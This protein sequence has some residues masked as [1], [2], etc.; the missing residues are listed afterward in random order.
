MA[1]ILTVIRVATVVAVVAIIVGAEVVVEVIAVMIISVIFNN[2]ISVIT[3]LYPL[4]IIK[5]IDL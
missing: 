5:L 1:V 4:E 2:S 3:S